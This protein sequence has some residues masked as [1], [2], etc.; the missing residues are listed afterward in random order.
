MQRKRT[1]RK[2]ALILVRHLIRVVARSSKHSSHKRLLHRVHRLGIELQERLVPDCPRAI[3]LAVV[4]KLVHPIV[5]IEACTS[6][7]RLKAHTAI[8]RT[9][10]ESGC[11]TFPLQA[12]GNR[13]NSI[14]G[15]RRNDIRLYEHRYRREHGRHSVDTL[16]AGS[17]GILVGHRLLQQGIKKRRI[18]VVALYI[19]VIETY[20]LLAERLQ[21]KHDYILGTHY[22]RTVRLVDRR[23]LFRQFIG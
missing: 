21:D 18:A 23:H 5:R 3:K 4:A 17:I 2:N 10:E 19:A 1:L 12:V 8:G 20:I 22:A 14:G 13:R 15:I 16:P 7:I 9:V 6:R 11:V